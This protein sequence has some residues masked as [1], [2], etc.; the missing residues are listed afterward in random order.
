MI[1]ELS[2]LEQELSELE[3]ELDEYQQ[4]LCESEQELA[5][6]QEELNQY[7]IAAMR[8]TE[9]NLKDYFA[10]MIRLRTQRIHKIT[11]T[12]HLRIEIMDII[13]QIMHNTTE[14]IRLRTGTCHEH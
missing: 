5:D 2:E 7:V 12:I 13:T 9:S 14:T 4:S 1:P 11:Q 8:S 3:Q 10:A 6:E